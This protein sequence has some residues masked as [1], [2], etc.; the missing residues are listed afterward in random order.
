MVFDTE[1]DQ[2]LC[3]WLD[4]HLVGSNRPIS[5]QANNSSLLDLWQ[6]HPSILWNL[7]VT[8]WI[9]HD[10]NWKVLATTDSSSSFCFSLDS[11]VSSLSRPAPQ[12]GVVPSTS[13]FGS[14]WIVCASYD[15]IL[16]SGMNDPFLVG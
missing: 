5:Q 2:Q 14:Y 8:Y 13:D 9:R 6:L 16:Y 7:R 11:L 12:T 3:W 10:S 15:P 4:Q 1:V